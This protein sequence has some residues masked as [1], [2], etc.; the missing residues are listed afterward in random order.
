M[1]G[2]SPSLRVAATEAARAPRL[3]VA[4]DFD[5]TLAPIVAEPGEARALDECLDAL[6]DLVGLP[7]VGVAVLS[8]RSLRELRLLLPG[9]DGVRLVGS[10]GAE[11][12]EDGDHVLSEDQE[13]LRAQLVLELARTAAT[14]SG[15]LLERKPAGAAVH[16][17]R[18]TRD[19][20]VRVLDEVRAGPARWPGVHVTEGKEVIELSVVDV[21]KGRAFA[22]LR[23]TLGADAAVF[24]G[25]DVTD[26]NVFAVLGDHDLSVKVGAGRSRAAHRVESPAEVALVLKALALARRDGG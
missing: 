11:W 17:R 21:D 14:A 7:G 8:G 15:V 13:R 24:L 18:A 5:G 23:D 16:V 2:L 9:A 6:R 25:D 12:D 22:R 4:T 20:A 19:D 26:E 3:L 10:H 1:S